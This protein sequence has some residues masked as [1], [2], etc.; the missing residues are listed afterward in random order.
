MIKGLA[1]T[2]PVLGRI[3]IGKPLI[4]LMSSIVMF[5]FG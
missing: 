4:M 1:I 5:K 3:R 2:P